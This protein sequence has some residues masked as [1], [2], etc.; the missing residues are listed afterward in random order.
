MRYW[1]PHTVQTGTERHG[2]TTL[3]ALTASFDAFYDAG[4]HSQ[5]IDMPFQHPEI[6]FR[7]AITTTVGVLDSK[8]AYPAQAEGP[9]AFDPSF[10]GA[11]CRSPL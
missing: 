11:F 7:P 5:N 2:I 10:V 4:R 8:K 3:Q 1:N 9:L 6:P